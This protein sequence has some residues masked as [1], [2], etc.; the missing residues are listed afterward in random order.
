M[1]IF[2]SGPSAHPNGYDITF[3]VQE[4]RFLTS[5]TGTQIGNNEG[6]MVSTEV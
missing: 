1:D 3:Q 5:T 2:F 6:N 4:K